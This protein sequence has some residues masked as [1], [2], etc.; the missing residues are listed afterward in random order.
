LRASFCK[1]LSIKKW[2][3][4]RRNKLHD[5]ISIS[6]GGDKAL[7]ASAISAFVNMMHEAWRVWLGAGKAHLGVAFYAIEVSA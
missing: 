4:A 7:R 2:I 1:R 6:D 5:E 3:G